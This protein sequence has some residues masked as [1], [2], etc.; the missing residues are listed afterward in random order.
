MVPSVQRIEKKNTE[1]IFCLLHVCARYFSPFLFYT[2]SDPFR[3]PP[4]KKEAHFDA[5]FHVSTDKWFREKD[6]KKK[7]NPPPTATKCTNAVRLYVWEAE[8]LPSFSVVDKLMNAGNDCQYCARNGRTG[9]CRTA[10]EC[11]CSSCI[12]KASS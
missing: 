12:K 8:E 4:K 11:R 9:D 2:G 6:P 1:K 10:K 5:K 3:F 7:S